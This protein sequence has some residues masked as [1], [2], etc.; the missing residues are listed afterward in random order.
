M[1]AGKNL[2][3]LLKDKNIT[4]TQLS[5]GTG[6]SSNTLYAIIKRD[7][8]VSASTIN[9]IAEY[10]DMSVD[11]LSELL[12]ENNYENNPMYE[13]TRSLDSDFTTLSNT[14]ELIDRLNDLSRAYEHCLHQLM[15]YQEDYKRKKNLKMQLEFELQELSIKIA[16]VENDIQTRRLELDM[17]RGKI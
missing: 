8:N 11:K 3:T 6:I 14:K 13:E 9:K 15:K 12:L 1:G 10:L 5:K 17:I 16:S 7:S 2:Q 4:V